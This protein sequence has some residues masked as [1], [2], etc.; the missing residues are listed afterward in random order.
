MLFNSLCLMKG[1]TMPKI[2]IDG[3][4]SYRFYFVSHDCTEKPHVHVEKD[5]AFAKIWLNVDRTVRFDEPNTKGFKNHELT[6]IQGIVLTNFD[7][8]WNQF[9]EYCKGHTGK[10]AR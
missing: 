8:I 10:S 6:A 4:R 2:N 3:V 1:I 9:H 7:A 5:A